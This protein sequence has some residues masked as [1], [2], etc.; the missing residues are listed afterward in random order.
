[1]LYD[2]SPP[3]SPE[4]AVW[5]GDVPLTREMQAHLAQG[6]PVTASALHTTVHLGA[7]ADA[8]A[9]IVRDGLSIDRCALEP[10]LGRCRVYRVAVGAR[11]AIKPAD[12]GAPVDTPRV[13][14]ATGVAGARTAFADD[15]AAPA[16]E[17]ADWLHTQGVQLLGVDTPSVDRFGAEGLPVHHRLI[18]HGIAILEGLDL[19]DVPAGV[20]ELC[21]LPLRLVG[22]D[23]S[24]VRAV[25]RTIDAT[26]E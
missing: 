12:L 3:L 2:I 24:P 10:F 11:G 19:A 21:A 6:D 23:A 22:F 9:H 7:H 4:L 13:L 5:P 14:L 20:Y 26:T 17:L 1:M 25:L 18:A 15:F 16:L 8:P